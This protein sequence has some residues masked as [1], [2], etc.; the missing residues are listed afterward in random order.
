MS[1]CS[2]RRTHLTN[3]V[4]KTFDATPSTHDEG[5][6]SSEEDNGVNALLR[7]QIVILDEARKV[8]LVAG[9]LGRRRQGKDFHNDQ[10]PR[11]RL[12]VNAPGTDTTT[13]FFPF[14]SEVL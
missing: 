9:W 3:L 12:T 14:H 1:S 6:V 13:T 10:I 5:I 4:R 8:L 2:E 7:E 11:L